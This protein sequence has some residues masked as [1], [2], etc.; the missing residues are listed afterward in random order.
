MA[1]ESKQRILLVEDEADL[2]NTLK[3]NLKEQGYK[4]STAGNGFEGLEKAR[5]KTPDLIILDLMLPGMD[6]LSLMR[7]LRQD[8]DVPVLMLTARTSEMDKI[9]GL[10]TGAD[11]YLTKP[12]SLGELLAR[13]RALLRRAER[14]TVRDVMTSGGI[15]LDLVSRRAMAGDEPLNLSP[16]EFSLLAELMRH[17]RAVLSRDL[18]LTRVW[19]YDYMGDTRTVDVHIRWLREKIEQD[20][21]RPMLLQTVRGIGYRFDGSGTNDESE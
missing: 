19:G 14:T 9:V 2:R 11:D 15:T 4:V 12:F 18:L 8:S 20:P 10:E 16:K 13:V 6:G 1:N 21:S 7:A 5:E 3:L 17:E